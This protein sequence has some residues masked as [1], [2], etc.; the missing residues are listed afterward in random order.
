MAQT[1]FADRIARNLGRPVEAACAVRPPGT[2]LVTALCA[3]LGAGLGA[4]VVGGAIFAG[5]GG[6]LGALVGYLVMWLRARS[7]GLAVAM[8]LLL[9]SDRVELVALGPLGTKPAGTIRS[10]LYAEIAGVDARRQLLEIRIALRT[11]EGVLELDGGRRGVGAA[12]P[13]V[14]ELRRRIAA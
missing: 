12:P 13:V 3:G 8:A 6:G 4:V 11:A 14:E 5:I 10:F 1:G 9:E 2:T 7:S